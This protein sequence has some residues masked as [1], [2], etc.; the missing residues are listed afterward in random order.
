MSQHHRVRTPVARTRSQRR[1]AEA[2][3]RR[4]ARAA[5]PPHVR[6][7]RRL[8]R[9]SWL[10][11]AVVL[12][13]ATHLLVVNVVYAQGRAAWDARRDQDAIDVFDRQRSVVPVEQ[14]KADFNAGTAYLRQDRTARALD[15]LDQALVGVPDAHRCAVQT[16]RALALEGE[17]AHLVRSAQDSLEK[18]EEIL[19]AQVA[20]DAGEPYDE[21]LVEPPYDDADPYVEELRWAQ[22][23]LDSAA[24][25]AALRI[26]ALADP[27]CTPPPSAGG[28]GGGGGGEDAQDARDEAREQA[29]QQVRE[30]G[31]LA[32]DVG[33]A[34]TAAEQGTSTPSPAPGSGTDPAPA[35]QD[36]EAQRQAELAERNEQAN[37]GG[38]GADPGPGDAPGD[39]STGG[40]TEPGQ[41]GTAPGG[42]RW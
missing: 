30:L 13:F 27:A 33:E 3:A 37:G 14:W 23:L 28:G 7:R 21:E 32:Q 6:R 17:Q 38:A 4:A 11:A 1:A 42:R 34:A 15:A 40:G 19:A 39:G 16:N 9:W 41:G 2:A 29:Q 10:P 12:G 18:A 26:E 36:A 20:R 25:Q 22:Y 5:E 24:D 35:P 31:E 8:L